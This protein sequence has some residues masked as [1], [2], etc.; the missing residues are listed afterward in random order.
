MN[1][2]RGKAF[3]KLLQAQ[4]AVRGGAVIVGDAGVFAVRC[5]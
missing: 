2:L 5:S 1:D 4:A 3:F